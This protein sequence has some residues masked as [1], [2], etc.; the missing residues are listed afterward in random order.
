MTL[1]FAPSENPYVVE[2]GG[3]YRRWLNMVDDLDELQAT[4]SQV[5]GTTDDVWVPLWRQV[6]RRHEDQGDRLEAS[7]DLE[8]ARRAYRQARVYYSIGRVPGA[9]TPLKKEVSDDCNRAFLK[10]VAHVDP[11]IEVVEVECEGR[12]IVSHFWRPATATAAAA[13]PAVLIMCGADMF[14]EDRGWAAEEAVANGMCALVMDAPGTGQNP[15][16]YEPEWVRA[17]VAAV[18]WLAARPEV[19]SQQIGAFGISRGGYSVLQL[20]GIYPEMVKAAVAIAGHPF[21]YRMSPEELEA[22]V[23]MKNQR[24]TYVFG[25]PGDPPTFPPTTVEEEEA[26]FGKW[27]LSELGLVDRIVCPVL[28]IN[29]KQ[30][31][32][33][34]IGNIYYMFEHGP[35][36]GREARI[37][38]DDGHCA[39]K[40]RKEWGPAVFRWLRE[41]L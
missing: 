1:A 39:F 35:V 16:P 33:A 32:L 18:D 12:G 7:G 14:K 36:T 29:G 5:T 10:E 27:A 17:W 13:V 6:G 30:D 40:Y 21:G 11:P 23:E 25:A 20:A 8:G 2:H 31:H 3:F 41:K 28:M 34:P 9:I 15:F 4:V 37:Y 19:E 26:Q 22:F 24:S 38:P